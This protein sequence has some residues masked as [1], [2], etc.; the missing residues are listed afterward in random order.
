MDAGVRPA[1]DDC[2]TGS[3]RQ[4]PP[5]RHGAAAH[6][7]AEAGSIDRLLRIVA[8]ACGLAVGSGLRARPRFGPGV[9]CS[10]NAAG[11]CSAFTIGKVLVADRQ[12]S[13]AA[14]FRTI[15]EAT[16]DATAELGTT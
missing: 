15:L 4:G 11:P 10:R 13:A 6:A 7:V 3:R 12:G 9:W 16:M 1:D 2:G 8:L 5:Q 14:A